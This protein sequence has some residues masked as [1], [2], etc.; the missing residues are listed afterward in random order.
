MRIGVRYAFSKKFVQAAILFLKE[1]KELEE[2]GETGDLETAYRSHSYSISS[3]V[4]S[5]ALLE[6]YINEQIDSL[7]QIASG[8]IENRFSEIGFEDI[9]RF[10]QYCD[11]KSGDFE[12]ISTLTKYQLVLDFFG[13]E[14]FEERG[15]FQ[16][17]KQLNQVRNYFVHYSPE[18]IE[19]SSL[20]K[21][22]DGTID[23]TKLPS[24]LIR[25]I[26]SNPL[27]EHDRKFPDRFIGYS[28][29]LWSLR[30]SVDLIRE[31]EDRIG[32]DKSE[33]WEGELSS[34]EDF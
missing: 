6:A 30:T 27:F 24:D 21:E 23:S 11:D 32:A 22:R 20:E 25:K 4:M 7:F 15:S 18:L 33:I 1:T 34:L 10:K 19:N 12:E 3:V 2:Q 8:D 28:L 5:H 29:G 16:A 13:L 9:S 31:F 26:D 17:A 14:S